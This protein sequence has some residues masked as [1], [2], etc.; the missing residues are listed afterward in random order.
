MNSYTG[1]TGSD[2]AT[3]VPAFKVERKPFPNPL[4]T[5]GQIEAP[6]YASEVSTGRQESITHAHAEPAPAYMPREA[7]QQPMNTPFPSNGP[8]PAHH[9]TSAPPTQYWTEVKDSSGPGM[10]CMQATAVPVGYQV[11]GAYPQTPYTQPDLGILAGFRAKV[12]GWS[13]KKKILVFG[14][15][16]LVLLAVIIGGAVGGT[17]QNNNDQKP[18]C[19]KAAQCTSANEK[20]VC[21]TGHCNFGVTPNTYDGGGNS[22]YGCCVH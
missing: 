13:K 11:N 21:G 7:M 22:L 16:G 14:A 15:T 5:H 3:A 8:G 10:G 18:S 1:N 2:G 9:G 4:P 6:T 17:V 19:G 12:A 20:S